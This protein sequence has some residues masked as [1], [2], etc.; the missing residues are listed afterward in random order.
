MRLKFGKLGEKPYTNQNFSV[1]PLYLSAICKNFILGLYEISS[2]NVRVKAISYIVYEINGVEIKQ[3]P[4]KLSSQQ[5]MILKTL[6]MKLP[7][8]L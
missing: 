6:N 8:R 3:L 7:H 4:T 1:N 2:S 5:Q